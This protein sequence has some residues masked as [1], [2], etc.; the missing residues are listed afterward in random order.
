MN[1]AKSYF[2]FLLLFYTCAV[3]QIKNDMLFEETRI[4][5]NGAL[6]RNAQI[7]SLSDF[8]KSAEH[9]NKAIDILKQIGSSVSARDELEKSIALLT[10]INE[11]VERYG[12]FF[13]DA[14]SSRKSA[15]LK[16]AD[17]YSPYYWN[18]AEE[19]LFDAIEE[20]K[21]RN[22]KEAFALVPTAVGFYLR[23]SDY[24]D[25]VNDLLIKWKPVKNADNYLAFLLSPNNYSEGLKNYFT[26]IEMLYDGEEISSVNEKIF[27]ATKYFDLSTSIAKDFA[28]V[29]SSSITSREEAR[30]IGAE[31][32]AAIEWQNAE[33]ILIKAG[34]EF[35]DKDFDSAKE[36]AAE[37]VQK[38]KISRQIAVKERFL[39]TPRQKIEL[40]KENDADDYA[41]KTF[42]NSVK[43][44]FQAE[45]LIESD[46][47]TETEVASIAKQSGYEADK[48]NWITNI[49]KT[50]KDG[51]A[52]WED[53][54]L[55]WNVWDIFKKQPGA[56]ERKEYIKTEPTDKPTTRKFSKYISDGSY[57]GR[58]AEIN[59][60]IFEEGDKILLRV[61]NINFRPTGWRLND[62]AKSVLNQLMIVLED[63]KGTQYQISSYTD[64]V[65][66]KRMNI[67]IS[68]S[69]AKTILDYLKE[70]SSYL[71]NKT[72]SAGYGEIN[73]VAD[74]SNFEGRRKNNRIEI[75]ISN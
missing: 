21:D 32:Y 14:L 13:N 1:T 37:A 64:N 8:K 38:Y 50:V 60:E 67:K 52:A 29:Y 59:M 71:S 20:F 24:A 69:R 33:E 45:N 42:D 41:P 61:Y 7:L 74:N 17:R 53:I 22:Y 54:I 31:I 63:F 68:E 19:N 75:L 40:A 44:Y 27:E 11:E 36:Y 62:E 34:R 4:T 66:A 49:I 43:Y 23:A 58:Y 3:A 5:F 2:L 72:T 26:S 47:Y 73:P 46:R 57:L 9:Y 28:K 18:L 12:D 55:S 39:F 48:A 70:Q 35:E 56:P 15:L 10:L 6:D 16:N 30:S 51:D 65:G 25:R